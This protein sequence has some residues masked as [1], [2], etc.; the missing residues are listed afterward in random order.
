MTNR[1]NINPRIQPPH[2]SIRVLPR[3]EKQRATTITTA[4]VGVGIAVQHRL[5]DT[6]GAQK[7]FC[8]KKGHYDSKS[9]SLLRIV[10]FVFQSHYKTNLSHMQTYF[11]VLMIY[12][13]VICCVVFN[14]HQKE[15]I[16]SVI[17]YQSLLII[18]RA[19]FY[20]FRKPFANLSQASS[21]VSLAFERSK[22]LCN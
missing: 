19:T 14:H 6:K 11:L 7:R 16:L 2:K 22:P 10:I 9:N 3:D 4:H 20:I 13:F 21:G 18:A 15:V 17:L 5:A 8:L 1:D 12:V